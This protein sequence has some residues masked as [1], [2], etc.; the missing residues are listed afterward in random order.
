[1]KR[2]V[3]LTLG[4]LIA[5]CL[6]SCSKD[7]TEVEEALPQSVEKI[8]GVWRFEEELKPENWS[9][10]GEFIA[11]SAD[12]KSEDNQVN[13][14]YQIIDIGT[15]SRFVWRKRYYYP[16]FWLYDQKKWGEREENFMTSGKVEI[17]DDKL[18]FVYDEWF[19]GAPGIVFTYELSA[20]GKQLMLHGMS[21]GFQ[22]SA[23]TLHFYK[24]EHLH[25]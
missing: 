8:S 15:N 21:D 5:F 20:D 22:P 24:E 17:T 14:L 16:H 25:Y 10:T 13:M 18:S 7:N 12:T 6:N 2:L 9:D 23:Y 19:M 3:F 1:M 11:S 4:L